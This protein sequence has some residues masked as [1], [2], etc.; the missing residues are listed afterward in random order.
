M[1]YNIM[2][3]Y[4]YYYNKQCVNDNEN[5]SIWRNGSVI[6]NEIVMKMS[7]QLFEEISIYYQP[8][9]RLV[10]VDYWQ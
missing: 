7:I 8:I 4:V 5:V 6:F 10:A 9:Y 3:A 2:T 1:K